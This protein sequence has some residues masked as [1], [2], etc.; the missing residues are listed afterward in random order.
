MGGVTV[1][2]LLSRH[3]KVALS[4]LIRLTARDRITHEIVD[5]VEARNLIVTA[6]KNLI[7]NMLVDTSGY[8]TGITYCALGTNTTAPAITD[9]QLGTETSRL[10]IAA[11]GSRTVATNVITFSTFFLAAQ[12][13]IFLKEVGLFGHS[14]ASATANSGVLLAHGQISYDNQAGNYDLTIDWLV[15]VS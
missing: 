15:T 1:N 4:G 11:N 13:S 14:T 8:D 9:T 2:R 7:A 3:D 10:E 12:C 5:V 6:G